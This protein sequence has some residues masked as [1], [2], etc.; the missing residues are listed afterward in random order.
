MNTQH[1]FGAI[2]ALIVIAVIAVAGG[3][4]YVAT[5][6]DAEVTIEDERQMNTDATDTETGG[7]TTIRE[8]LALGENLVCTFSRSDAESTVDG[9]IY[10]DGAGERI[11]GDFTITTEAAG[12]MQGRMVKTENTVYTWTDA[13]SRGTKMSLDAT[14]EADASMEQHEAVGLDEE[15]NYQCESW[16]VDESRFTIPSDIEFMDISSMMDASMDVHG[17]AS[18]DQCAACDAIPDENAKQQCL[19]SLGCQ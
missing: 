10:V 18:A 5:Q 4:I 1:G 11:S 19:T 3:G 15:V 13:M 17:S 9:T 7:N 2:A 8:L 14:A 12:T 16:N 6:N